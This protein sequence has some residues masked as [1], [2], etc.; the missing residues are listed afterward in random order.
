MNE[1]LPTEGKVFDSW[2]PFCDTR[3]PFFEEKCA[4]YECFEGHVNASH[5]VPGIIIAANMRE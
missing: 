2:T 1:T 5:G 4:D 3:E